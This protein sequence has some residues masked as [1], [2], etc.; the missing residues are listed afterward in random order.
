M[1]AFVAKSDTKSDTS[2]T[3]PKLKALFMRPADRKSAEAKGEFWCHYWCH[4]V[5]KFGAF[6]CDSVRGVKVSQAIDN[7]RFVPPGAV[8]CKKVHK[9]GFLDSKSAD[10]KVV[11][12]RPPPRAP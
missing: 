6:W 7:K 2:Q 8:L 3:E 1:L 9:G 5:L 4:F 11:G 12:V 10:R